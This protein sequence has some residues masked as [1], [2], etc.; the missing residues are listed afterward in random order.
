MKILLTGSLKDTVYSQNDFLV[1]APAA[2]V[3]INKKTDY[4]N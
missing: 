1:I 4:I 3:S 2:I